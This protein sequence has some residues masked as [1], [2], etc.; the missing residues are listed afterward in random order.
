[1]PKLNKTMRNISINLKSLRMKNNYIQDEISEHLEM[2][3][4]TYQ[5]LEYNLSK[6]IKLSTI[7]K[8]LDYYKISFDKLINK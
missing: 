7:L 1:M 8:I 5:K 2:N 6:D 4:R 3:R